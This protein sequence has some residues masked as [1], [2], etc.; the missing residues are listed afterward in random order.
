M[1]T[2][3]KKSKKSVRLGRPAI[4]PGLVRDQRLDVRFARGEIAALKERAAKAGYR[5]SDWVRVKL[6]L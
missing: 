4:D 3:A 5:W 2:I 6:G 1:A